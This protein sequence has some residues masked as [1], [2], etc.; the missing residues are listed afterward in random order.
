M[1]NIYSCV[2]I[3][4]LLASN[5]Q[6]S[7]AL[8][9]S[10][11]LKTSYWSGDRSLTNESDI[12]LAGLWGKARLSTETAGQIIG[13]AWVQ[14][15]TDNNQENSLLR[16]L[17]WRFDG[18]NWQLNIGKQLLAW[19]RADGINPTDNLSPRDFT[20]LAPEDNDLRK[21]IA[22]VKGQYNL[23]SSSISLMWF[24]EAESHRI[25]LEEIPGI[26]YRIEDAPEKS[27]YAVQWEYLGASADMSI[28]WFDGYDLMP[29]LLPGSLSMQGLEIIQRNQR[30]QVL[31]GDL[32]FAEGNRVWRAEI[33]W[34]QTDSTGEADFT[35]K[36]DQLWFVGGPEFTLDN[37][38]VVGLQLSLK[39]VFDFAEPDELLMPGI[40]QSVAQRQLATANQ[41]RATQTGITWRIAKSALNDTVQFETSGVALANHEGGLTRAHVDYMPR[42]A[43]HIRLGVENYRGSAQTFFGQLTKNSLGYLEVTFDF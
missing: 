13:E 36:K 18:E 42:D 32:S 15:D 14:S 5:V 22:A 41:T 37:N 11:T 38:W 23:E 12:G 9:A 33:A 35:H 6:A 30:L 26:Y 19:G 21:G 8:D 1:K 31:G 16:E 43:M 39:R 10:G 24:P 27:Q 28:S 7:P 29:D 40:E 20:Q 17:Y 34:S 2:G 3:T 4:L 25:P